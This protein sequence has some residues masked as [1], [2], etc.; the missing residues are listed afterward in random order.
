VKLLNRGL[1]LAVVGAGLVALP[2]LGAQALPAAAGDNGLRAMKDQAD[3]SLAISGEEATGKVGF[4]R[5]K[6][7]GD[8]L[9]GRP[10]ASSSEAAAKAD[11]YLAKYAGNFGARPGE[12]KQTAVKEG[13][14]G[15]TITYQ[16]S[17]KGVPVFGGTL[18]ANVD[19]EGDLTAV[20]G[21]AAPDLSLD[22]TPGRPADEAA[23]RA[24][25]LVKA[26]P[27]TA[28]NGG[29]ADLT[30]L[31]AAS[32]ELVVYREGAVKGDSGKSLLAYQVEVTNVTK[33]GGNVRDMVFLDANTLKP[34]NRYSLV[35]DALERYL[36][37]TDYSPAN[38]PTTKVKVTPVWGE[39]DPFPGTLN[40]DQQNLLQS[41]EESY[42]MFMNA[43]GVD[44]YDA[45]GGERI[46]LHNRP[47]SCPNAS[48]NGSYTSYCSGVY[49]DDVVSHEWG[50]AY[51]EYN[52][53][54]IYQW[55]SGA[56]NEAYSD[57]YGESL[58][59]INNREDAGEG[60]LT[61]KRRDGICSSHT[62]GD[63]TATIT[64]PAA[65]AGDCESAA[66]AAFG[67]QFTPAGV[68]SEVVVA[69]DAAN[70][71]G[72]KTTDGC[73][74]IS[75]GAALAGK[76]AYVDRGTCAFS[77]KVRNVKATGAS[78]I[79]FGN[80]GPGALSVSGNDPDL[81]GLMVSQADGT[82]IK[83]VGSVT[84]TVK[85]KVRD[86]DDSYRWLIGE[87]SPA[88]G[89]AIRDMWNPTCYGDPGKVSDAEYH[90][91]SDDNGGVHGNSAVPN[92]GYAL[93]VDG[94][95]YNGV[96]VKGLGLDKALNIYFKAQNEYLVPTSSFVDHADS[97]E[98][99]C[100]AL[101]DRP[102]NKITVVRNTSATLGARITAA[103]CGEV[104]KMIDAVQLRLDPTAE[105]GWEPILA[106]SGQPTFSC[107]NGTS[108]QTLFAD[109]F[110]G[111]LTKWTTDQ[112]VV[113]TGAEG[114]PWM[115]SDE[116]PGDHAGGVAYAPDLGDGDCSGDAAD[117]SGRD[118]IVS[119]AISVPV[120]GKSPR[121]SFDHYV[122]TEAGYD[123][124]NVKLKV[125]NGAFTVIP[126]AAFVFNGYNET[127]E[128]AAA[129]NTNPMAGEPAFSGTNPGSVFG[130]W[131]TSVVDLEKAGVK[132]G[133]TVQL[134]FDIG[135]DGCGGV[136][137]WYVDNVKVQVCA[138]PAPAT[139]PPAPVPAAEKAHSET[140]L[141][142]KPKKPA[143]KQDFKAIVKV[144]SL[145]GKTPTGKVKFRLDGKKLDFKNLKDGRL[146]LKV[147]KNIKVGKH[148]LVAT[149]KGD[150]NTWW[151]RDR[152]RVFIVR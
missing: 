132:A 69:T 130:S 30:G 146:V 1:A 42:W 27:P 23:D 99:S 136:D 64:A 148:M 43:W 61:A 147:K 7:N 11:A 128:T 70:T 94:G 18:K 60:D 6:G 65:V 112:Q 2:T 137:G 80:S 103:D 77:V 87:K 63:I 31:R 78:G 111:G 142:I 10:G 135:R 62:R 89:G 98:A 120:S 113:Y 105:C 110:E 125:G 123:G 47:D 149:Y 97:L 59:L 106:T 12:L 37:T 26:H 91:T 40:Q 58:D 9:P 100:D 17:Y 127:L 126:D 107:G 33:E 79:V 121:L 151:S 66:P 49:A 131:G 133:D 152:L 95:T 104:S 150:T 28:E 92:H 57:I 29:A 68:T 20:N 50:H 51:T 96:T 55:Q 75:N 139:T 54:L 115:A 19:A 56:L 74:A 45:R 22:V 114:R 82:R 24:L 38:P 3:G 90:C 34:V 88:F 67:P 5:V 145:G 85:E 36:Y 13:T 138:T 48:W 15:W 53:G 119:P 144:K 122:A 102:I 81:Y 143:F 140:T 84:M 39:G 73:T 52:S 108:N 141:K 21:F 76:W 25:S 14:S 4:I 16:Q 41:S 35:T 109:D 101:I 134:R 83:S 124:G 93:L 129:D 116:A 32:N 8:L 86:S 46:T 71:D 118:S 44:S 117:I 72:P